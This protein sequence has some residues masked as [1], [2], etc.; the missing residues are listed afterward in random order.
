MQGAVFPAAELCLP[1]TVYPSQ[2]L[3]T[4]SNRERCF[5]VYGVVHSGVQKNACIEWNNVL[6]YD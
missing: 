3:V 2:A 5:H 6:Y 1:F 4:A